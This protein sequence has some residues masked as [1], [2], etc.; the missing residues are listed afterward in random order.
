MKLPLIPL[1][2]LF[3]ASCGGPPQVGGPEPA[4]H[5]V[6]VSFW[7]IDA[8]IEQDSALISEL[9]P[10]RVRVSAEVGSV[11]ASASSRLVKARPES[12]LGALV[13]DALLAAGR[14]AVDHPVHTALLNHGGLR[15]PLPAG[16]VTMGAIYELMPFENRVTLVQL[17]GARFLELADQIASHGGEPIAGFTLVIDGPDGNAR[18]VRVAG[19]V[20]EPDDTVWLATADFVAD[21]GGG[22]GA[23]RE[24][25]ARADLDLLVRDAIAS[26]VERLGNLVDET[27][28]RLLVGDAR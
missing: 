10:Y 22:F 17:S 8:D 3:L 18:D 4:S 28:R 11:L 23:L 24:P 13:A 21:G 20:V 2:A 27:P 19:G 15:A 5:R 26:H 14:Q 25:L 7:G 9:A 12:A 1:T 6:G 16:D